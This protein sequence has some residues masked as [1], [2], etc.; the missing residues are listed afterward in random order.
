MAWRILLLVFMFPAVLYAQAHDA[1]EAKTVLGPSNVFLFDGARALQAGH[2]EEGV[3]LTQKGLQL[4]QGLR[5]EKIGHSN[6][7]AGFVLL[8]QPQSALEH[9]NWVLE[10][11]PFHWRTYNN[12]ALAYMQLGRYE[13]SEADVKR[14]QELS[15]NSENLK[16]VKGMLLD[17]TDPVIENIIIDDRRS[18]PDATEDDPE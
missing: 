13:E 15:P 12:R 16:E 1:G 11:D 18:P 2:G 9:C 8:R 6:L 14:G 5:E 17:E 4:A 10:R 7:C 3:K